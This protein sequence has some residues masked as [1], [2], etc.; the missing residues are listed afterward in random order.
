MAGD[1]EE[2]GKQVTGRLPPVH[3]EVPVQ[4]PLA[5]LLPLHPSG[6]FQVCELIAKQVGLHVSLFLGGGTK[7]HHV[8]LF[9]DMYLLIAI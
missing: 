3:G 4:H 2:D 5:N 1:F 9:S 8:R 6:K 7:L